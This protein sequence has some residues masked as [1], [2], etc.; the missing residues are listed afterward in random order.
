MKAITGFSR[1][2]RKEM[3]LSPRKEE[4]IEEGFKEKVILSKVL[5]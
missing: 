1:A 3:S 2:Q 4:G 5:K